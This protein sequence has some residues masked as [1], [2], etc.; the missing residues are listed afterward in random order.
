M[1]PGPNNK[2][3]NT[4]SSSSNVGNTTLQPP[5]TAQLVIGQSNQTAT[6]T[7]VLPAAPAGTLL[8]NS[9]SYCTAIAKNR[10]LRGI[11]G[12]FLIHLCLLR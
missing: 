5:P 7:A 6:A 12:L 4:A 3:R 1:F 8:F 10:H 2:N 11:Q 9:V